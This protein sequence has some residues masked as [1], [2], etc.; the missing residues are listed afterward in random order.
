MGIGYNTSIVRDGL[1]LYLDAANPKSYPGSGTTWFD[2][3]G[4]NADSVATVLPTFISD[5]PQSHWVFNGTNNEFNSVNISQEYR[6]LIIFLNA[7][8]LSSGLD[9]VFGNYD[10]QDDSLRFLDGNLRYSSPIDSNDWQFNSLSDIM[11]NGEYIT[12]DYNLKDRWSMIRTYR[13]NESGFGTSFRYEISSSFF[14]SSRMYQGKIAAI[15]CYNRKLT[16]SEVKQNFE[17]LRGR[18]GI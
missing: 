17:A 9:M 7:D 16:Q 1:V 2:L 8:P 13:S 11:I 6:D 3:S 4:Q 14:S 5:G 10:N 12:E 15:M 18:Y